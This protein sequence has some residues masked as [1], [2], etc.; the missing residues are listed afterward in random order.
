VK[1]P[2]TTRRDAWVIPNGTVPETIPHDIAAQRLKDLLL[3][4]ASKLARP[5]VVPRNLGIYWLEAFPNVGIDPDVCVLDPPPPDVHDLDALCLWKP[6]HLPP[7]I[8]FEIVTPDHPHKDYAEL[9][10]RYAILGTHEL[11]VFDPYLVGSKVF[12][13]PFPLQVW[14][15]DQVGYF[16]RVYAGDSSAL[17]E[18]LGAWLVPSKKTLEIA[19][20]RDGA[21]CWH[22]WDEIA[23]AETNLGEA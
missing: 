18:S 7:S 1:Y 23:R 6:G 22:T 10:D 4:W 9:H 17:S 12:G 14:R 5:C 13:G 20:D 3:V 2:V 16:E 8:C 11:V 21:N 15:R 19:D